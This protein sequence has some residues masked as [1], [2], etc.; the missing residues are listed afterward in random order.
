MPDAT[1]R[2]RI[3]ASVYHDGTGGSV[4]LSRDGGENWLPSSRGLGTRD[5]FAFYQ[6]PD[7]TNT[8]YAGTNTGV[9][10]SNDR[11]ESWTFVGTPKETQPVPKKPAPST[12]TWPTR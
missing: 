3:L 4:F 10:R 2:G 6:M 7:D 12:T 8:I 11:G 5:V 9:F 1:E